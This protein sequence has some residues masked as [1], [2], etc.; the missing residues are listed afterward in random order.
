[1]RGSGSPLDSCTQGA[2]E[3]AFGT[4]FGDVR[5]H[6]NAASDQLNQRLTSRAFTTGNDIFLRSDASPT[7]SHLMAHELSHVVQQRSMPA[8]GAALQ[9][10]QAGDAHGQAADA[11]ADAFVS[12][13]VVQREGEPP[14]EEELQTS[15]DVAQREGEEQEEDQS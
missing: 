2:M 10:G 12:R 6:A 3:S 9:G 1:M 5:V 8:S 11:N 13:S 15:R 7:D 14:P 4:G